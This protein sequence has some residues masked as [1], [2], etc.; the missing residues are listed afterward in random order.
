MERTK[1]DVL[2]FADDNTLSA[3]AENIINLKEQLDKAAIEALKWLESNEMIANPDKGDS[4]KKKPSIPT[5]D[6]KIT[7]G[8]QEIKP[9]VSVKLLG[10]DIDEKLNFR[11]HITNLCKKAGAK[12]NAIKRLGIFLNENERKLLIDAHVTAP[13]HYSSTVW[14]FCEISQI[15]KMEKLHERCIRFIYNEYDKEYFNILVEKKLNTLYGER[16][17]IMCCET[18]KTING[19]NA[20]YMKD[21]FEE[22][23]SKYPSRNENNLYIPKANQMTYGYKSYRVQGPKAWNYLTNEVKE[24]NSYDTFLKCIINLEMPFCS[25]KK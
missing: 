14:H 3:N 21:I 15:H 4:A 17:Q 11:K 2:N 7:V 6:I 9:D 24:A 19:L 12:L 8:N 1:T 16:M 13:F 18:Y 10:V 20:A 5:D 22:R 23:P 25:C